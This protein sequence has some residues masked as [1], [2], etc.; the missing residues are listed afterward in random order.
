MNPTIAAHELDSPPWSRVES[1]LMSTARLIRESYD[2]RLA[3][4]DL[5]LTQATVVAYL[6]EFGAATQTRIAGHLG[7]G[8]AAAGVTIDRLQERGIV[9][10]AAD[11]VDRRVWIVQLTSIG[12]DLVG[13]IATVDEVLR[14]ELRAGIPR[15]ERRALA[16]LLYKLQENLHGVIAS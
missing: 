15:S 8:R 13:R 12:R 6:A 4:L 7:Q 2:R 14:Q 1:T 10:R 5:N 11:P 9:T 16:V 3:P